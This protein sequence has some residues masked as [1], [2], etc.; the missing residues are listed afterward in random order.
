MN[1]E[2]TDFIVELICCAFEDGTITADEHDRA[3]VILTGVPP[4][5]DPRPDCP[6]HD[7]ACD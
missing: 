5:G 3:H 7:G 1:K 6:I 2:E 4:C